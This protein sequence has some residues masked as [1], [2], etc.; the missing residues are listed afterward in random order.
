LE[1]SPPKASAEVDSLQKRLDTILEQQPIDE[2]AARELIFAIAVAQY[3]AIGSEEYETQRL[4]RVFTSASP[5]TELDANLLRSTVSAIQVNSNGEISV[6]LKN[7]QIV[8]RRK[9]P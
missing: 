2:N 3:D 8:E 4:R 7:G 9:T 1:Q 5:M 6:R